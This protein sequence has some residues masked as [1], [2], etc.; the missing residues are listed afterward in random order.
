V[1]RRIIILPALNELEKPLRPPFLEQ[2]HQRARDRLHLCAGNFR[3]PTVAIDEAACNL[4]EFKIPRDIR[5]HEDLGEFARSDDKFGNEI[6]G[7][8]A[9]ATEFFRCSVSG[10]ELAPELRGGRED[11][12][13]SCAI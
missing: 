11:D 8:V 12:F 5:V 1:S 13:K 2:T 7:I 9:V 4:L 6:D 10:P 3:D